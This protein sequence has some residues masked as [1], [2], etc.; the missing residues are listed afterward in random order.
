M[1]DDGIGAR[2]QVK[3]E[4]FTACCVDSALIPSQTLSLH[5][6]IGDIGV[7]K[8]VAYLGSRLLLWIQ[9]ANTGHL[10][11]SAAG[12]FASLNSGEIWMV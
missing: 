9:H 3:L 11:S 5:Y 4:P 12:L 10:T 1:T 7:N 8:T 6:T 2:R